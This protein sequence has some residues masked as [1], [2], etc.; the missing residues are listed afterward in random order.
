MLKL[1]KYLHSYFNISGVS[2]IV[3]VKALCYKL[4]GPGFET[5]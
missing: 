4:Q 5:R 1:I 3:V 2:G